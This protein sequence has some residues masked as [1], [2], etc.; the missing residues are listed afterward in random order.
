MKIKLIGEAKT[1]MSNP[2]GNHRYF[3]WP[4]MA[5]LKDGRIAVGASGF[6]VEHVCPFGKGVIAFSDDEGE[7][8]SAPKAVFDTV[9][10]D[11]DVGLTVFGESGL[12]ATSFNNT[13]EFQRHNMPQTEECFDYINSVSAEDEEKALGVSFRISRDNGETFGEIYKSPVT[14]PHGPI[15]LSDGKILWVGT[16]YENTQRVEAHVINPDNGCVSH[17]STIKTEET[18]GPMLDEPNAIQLP[19]GR[20]ICHF[21]VEEE[22]NKIF[23]LLQSVSYDNGKSWSNPEQIIKD[24]SGA[25]AHL[26]LHSSGI[27]ISAFSRRAFPYGI[28]AVFSKD[29]GETWS[30]E[31]KLY[32]NTCSDDIGYPSTVELDDGSLLTA[33]YAVEGDE[34]SPAVIKQQKWCFESID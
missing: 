25:P 6:R 26:F 2:D 23:T 16:V 21:R 1:I 27:L 22:E 12:I 24:D 3:G 7:S 13:L 19:D 5:R 11:R 4:T 34:N 14:S 10:D 33:F 20:I 15:V 29:G 32:E 9:L 17:Y 8:Y 31:H 18:G 28:R 30:E